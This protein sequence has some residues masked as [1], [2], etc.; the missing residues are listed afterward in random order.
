MSDDLTQPPNS[1][2]PASG[3][4]DANH[5]TIISLC[6]LGSFITGITGIVG[7]V[8]AYV[9]RDDAEEWERS[10][11]TYLIRTFWIGLLASVLLTI[12]LIGIMLLFLPAIWVGVRS[13]MS[14]VKAQK[15]EPMPDPETW[16][17]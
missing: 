16:L 8:L 4:F 5:P 12:T 9:W 6:Y 1:G 17:F 10:H 3:G 2:P 14:L 7:I 11:Y 15:R 13:V